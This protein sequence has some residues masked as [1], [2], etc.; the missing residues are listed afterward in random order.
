MYP[1]NADLHHNAGVVLGQ[2]TDY[3]AASDQFIYALLMKP[4]FPQART[5]LRILLR[6]IGQLP[7]GAA[8]LRRM[9]SIAPDSPAIL[10]DIA[11][12]YATQPDSAARNGTEAVRLA[13]HAAILTKRD[14]PEVLI[15]LAA[16]YAET[17]RLP[18]AIKVAEEA[19]SL[20]QSLHNAEI[21]KLADKVL[22]AFRQGKTYQD[23]GSQK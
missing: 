4:Y 17:G 7:D 20:A 9:E 16:A 12:S 10:N 11:W 14:T 22:V 13:E 23:D 5:N 21:S 15:T 19:R 1:F 2:T 6:H 3:V 8:S 18:D